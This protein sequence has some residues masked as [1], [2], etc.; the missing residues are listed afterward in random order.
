MPIIW[1]KSIPDMGDVQNICWMN[2]KY[3]GKHSSGNLEAKKISDLV[4]QIGSVPRVLGE[5]SKDK[6]HS[7]KSST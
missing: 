4:G 6:V 7:L 2:S 1:N 5:A 3:I